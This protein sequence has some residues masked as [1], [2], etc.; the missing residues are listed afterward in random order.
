MIDELWILYSHWFTMFFFEFWG[1]IEHGYYDYCLI[2]VDVEELLLPLISIILTYVVEL[3]YAFFSW[4]V[5]QL[6]LITSWWKLS[7][8]MTMIIIII[9]PLDNYDHITLIFTND[10]YCCDCQWKLSLIMRIVINWNY[11]Y[12]FHIWTIDTI[13]CGTMLW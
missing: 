8:L 9:R 1:L 5:I 11:C 10:Y 13:C 3:S 12:Q 7:P 6:L 2:P 4:V